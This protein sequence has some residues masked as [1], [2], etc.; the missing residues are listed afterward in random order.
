MKP[1]Y[2]TEGRPCNMLAHKLVSI[3]GM[4]KS[5]QYHVDVDFDV[6]HK[7]WECECE[8]ALLQPGDVQPK[9]T[10]QCPRCGYNPDICGDDYGG[11]KD[12]L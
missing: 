4:L 11:T 7:C 10:W 3:R 1:E 5:L 2:N 8:W 12:E 6:L 9:S